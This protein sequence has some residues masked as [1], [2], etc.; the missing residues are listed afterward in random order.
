M[1]QPRPF[2]AQAKKAGRSSPEEVAQS[3]FEA[4]LESGSG[5]EPMQR[6]GPDDAGENQT[7]MPDR[8][9]AGLEELSGMDIS[10]GVHY[11]SAKPVAQREPASGQPSSW[12]GLEPAPQEGG[13]KDQGLYPECEE[14]G[15]VQEKL[16]LGAPGDIY[17]Q[18][19]ERVAQKV[20]SF[21][22]SVE[23]DPVHRLLL[24][25]L[26]VSRALG[27]MGGP[28]QEISHET[29]GAGRAPIL[30]SPRSSARQEASVAPALE[31]RIL[32]SKGRGDAL[33]PRV[34]RATEIQTGYDFSGVRVKTDSEAADL[35]RS[36]N[37]R[38][39]THGSDIWL[40]RGESVDDTRLMAHELTHVVQQGAARR[41]SRREIPGLSGIRSRDTVRGYLL[42]MARG[43]RHDATACRD[44]ARAFERANPRDRIDALQR[45]LLEPSSQVDIRQ[46]SGS[47]TLRACG[48]SAPATGPGVRAVPTNFRQ[49]AGRDAGG[50][51]LHFEYAWDST[52]G[53]LADLTGCR[54]GEKVDYTQTAD[55]PFAAAPNPTILWVAATRGVAQDNHSPGAKRPYRTFTE[56]VSQ[57]YRYDVDGGTPVDIA[58]PIPIIRKITEKD[59]GDFKYEITKSGLKAEIDPLP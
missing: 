24:S 33:P 22:R 28:P 4:Y 42:G 49:T 14:V 34:R 36:L 11:N 47:E 18:E 13:S 8:L 39:F 32:A 26:E 44:E 35:S 46:R 59:N 43:S 50:G 54:T 51:V 38:A 29:T 37:A 12:P 30:G 55:P 5:V 6:R 16:T 3:P 40:G 56:R 23:A 52:S 17:E 9:E 27:L 2:A 19:A 1:F 7:G 53:S 57:T 48:R 10:G 45:Q 31:R 20:A 58:G 41:I 25:R 21:S 15:K